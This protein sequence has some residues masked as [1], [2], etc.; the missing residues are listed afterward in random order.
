MIINWFDDRLH[1]CELVCL[2]SIS[3]TELTDTVNT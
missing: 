3:N 2:I 1:Q